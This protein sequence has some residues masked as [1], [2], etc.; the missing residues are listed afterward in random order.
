MKPVIAGFLTTALL[1][2]LH[3]AP[4]PEALQSYGSP[5]DRAFAERHGHE[6][7]DALRAELGLDH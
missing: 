6:S 3:V 7:K 1:L 2:A 5:A 4:P